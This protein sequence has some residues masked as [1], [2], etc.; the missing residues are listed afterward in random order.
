MM[1]RRGFITVV[2]LFGGAQG[3]GRSQQYMSRDELL[4]R[5]VAFEKHHDRFVRK[6]IGC[7]STGPLDETTCRPARGIISYGDFL[8]ARHAAAKLYSLPEE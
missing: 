1:L 2:L 4:A 6:L 7:P 5:V 8:N 3:T